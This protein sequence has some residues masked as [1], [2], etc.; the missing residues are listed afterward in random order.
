MKSASGKSGCRGDILRAHIYGTNI[1]FQAKKY[2]MGTQCLWHSTVHDL[3]RWDLHLAHRNESKQFREAYTQI[4]IFICWGNVLLTRWNLH[5]A[6]LGV[7]GIFW[8]LHHTRELQPQPEKNK[9]SNLMNVVCNVKLRSDT[10]NCDI[11]ICCCWP[12]TESILANSLP[13]CQ[14]TFFLHFVKQRYK[15]F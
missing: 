11:L 7:E 1:L 5:L 8:E 14:N 9:F 4:T 10:Q 12:F 2:V 13:I 15:P 6:N 3:N